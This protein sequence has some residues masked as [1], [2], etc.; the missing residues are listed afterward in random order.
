M[1]RVSVIMPVHNGEKYLPAAIQSVLEL[2]IIDDGSTDK[3]Y[4]IARTFKDRR[5]RIIRNKE[6]AGLV[7]VR[8]QGLNE[9]KTEYAAWLDAD[10]IA[11]P[12]RLEKQVKFLDTN[13]KFGLIG[14]SVELID[15]SGKK[16]GVKWISRLSPAKIP[17]ALIFNNCFTQS[18]VM[19][20]KSAGPKEAYRN[21]YAP[22]EDYDL[23]VRVAK[24]WSV[25]NLPDILVAYRIH[26]KN[27]SV[28]KKSDKDA[29]VEKIIR[30]ELTSIGVSPTAEE[31]A[32]HRKNFGFEETDF[33]E[34]A[35]ARENWLSKLI[36]ANIQAGKFG[37]NIFSEVVGEM[38]LSTCSSNCR[39]GLKLWKRYWSSP[40]SDY[41][42]W[43]D[44]WQTI[45]KFAIKCLLRKDSFKK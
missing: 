19:M 28:A 44:N 11:Y 20:R 2:I 33:H 32:L 38:W 37:K 34:F 39:H 43:K 21:G 35:R 14:S 26:P 4:D 3:T 31:Y 10:D 15:E 9:A 25:W 13:P 5:I 8:N 23:W 30:S 17:A 16:T 12:K 22:A 40:L 29:A 1:P 7:N 45:I 18:S 24:D 41:I 6:K 27:E 42:R 36:E